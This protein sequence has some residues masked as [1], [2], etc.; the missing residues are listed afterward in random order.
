MAD[1]HPNVALLNRIYVTNLDSCAE[2]FA[3]DVVWHYYNPKLPQIEGDYTG[4]D[5]I[6][7]FFASLAALTIGTFR[8]EPVSAEPAGDELVVVR[9]R[10]TLTIDG[11]DMA[12][13]VIVVWRIVEGKISEVWD[14]PSVFT[15][16]AVE[17]G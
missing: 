14:I 8:V 2:V 1:V 6:K 4:L 3:N 12:T 10:N 13:D 17:L 11:D 16:T 5:G 15:D 9:T 7:S